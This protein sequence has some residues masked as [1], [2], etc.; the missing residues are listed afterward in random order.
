V[1]VNDVTA[2][3]TA[4]DELKRTKE[5]L[6][7]FLENASVGI[8]WVN[9]EGTILYVN[10]AELE[11]LGYSKDEYLGHNIAEFYVEQEE[12]TDIFRRLKSKE[13]IQNNEVKLRCKNGTIRYALVSSNVNW[14]EGQFIHT[15]CFTR[16]ITIR[17]KNEHLL[18]LLNQ[19]SQQL[20]SE[21]EFD[22]SL[23]RV[24]KSIVPHFADWFAIYLLKN[25]S[26]ELLKMEY[27]NTDKLRSANAYRQKTTINLNKFKP[28]SLAWVLKIGKP[29]H[30]EQVGSSDLENIA[31]DP[32]QLTLLNNLE[33]KSL[34]FVPMI[35]KGSVIG[36]VSFI[37]IA[38]HRVFDVQDFTFAQDLVARIAFSVE[39]VR[40]HNEAKT[41]KAK[42]IREMQAKTDN[43]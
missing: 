40:L 23:D 11:L 39:N 20:V 16:D 30:I 18:M 42:Y 5:E 3:K 2:R 37:S 33:I 15:R 4:E 19:V 28:N 35:M 25:N 36:A 13:E 43:Q 29:V 6:Q 1:Y 41:L 24:A 34:I 27:T 7:D 14:D 32:E 21:L 9:E 17:K 8:H 22:L 12:I 26:V 31:A 38:P 10:R